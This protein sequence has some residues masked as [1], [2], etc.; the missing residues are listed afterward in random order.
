MQLAAG[1]AL[2]D[3][4]LAAH[5]NTQASS[6]HGQA[7]AQDCAAAQVLSA[8]HAL[9]SVAHWS[10]EHVQESGHADEE[11]SMAFKEAEEHLELMQLAAGKALID[12]LLAAHFNTQAS[13]LHGQ[14]NAQDCAAAQVPSAKHAL[15]SVAHLSKEHVQESGQAEVEQSMLNAFSAEMRSR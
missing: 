14:A 10:K 2:I 4:L 6:L 9:I 15:I 5:F 8:K 1:K 7:R 3:G 13:S 12:G 11:Q